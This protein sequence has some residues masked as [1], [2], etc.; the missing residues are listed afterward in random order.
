MGD[1]AVGA[2][3]AS[4]G[5][6]TNEADIGRLIEVLATFRDADASVRLAPVA[7]LATID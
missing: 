2:V 3:R 4:L 6:A 7:E 5:I 1:Q